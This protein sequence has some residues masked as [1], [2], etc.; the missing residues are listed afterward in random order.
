M[1]L[2]LSAVN[3]QYTDHQI[4]IALWML[5]YTTLWGISVGFWLFLVYQ[6]KNFRNWAV[7]YAVRTKIWWQKLCGVKCLFV[8]VTRARPS[9]QQT[10]GT[11]ARLLHKSALWT[12]LINWKNN[13]SLAVCS[14]TFLNL[15]KRCVKTQLF[16]S[17]YNSWRSAFCCLTVFSA[18]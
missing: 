18:R 3:L 1:L 12:V 5:C 15:F 9:H 10:P 14:T 6:W 8:A 17:S 4:A 16:Q 7:F 2:A 11:S 13:L